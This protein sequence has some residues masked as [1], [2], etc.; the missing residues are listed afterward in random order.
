[1]AAGNNDQALLGPLAA[2]HDSNVV[3]VGASDGSGQ[4][5]SFS[6][7]DA[8]VVDLAAPGVNVLGAQLGGGEAAHSGTSVSTA[9]VAGTAAL[10]WGQ[11]PDQ[12]YEQV[13][14]ALLAGATQE[15]GLASGV[16]GGR[17]LNVQGALEADA[18]LAATPVT[19]PTDVQPAV[20]MA[21]M[22]VGDLQAPRGSSAELTAL[23][24]ILFGQP[25]QPAKD[26]GTT[27]IL[28]STTAMLGVN[29]ICTTTPEVQTVG[30][31]VA[32][33]FAVDMGLPRAT[34]TDDVNAL[35]RTQVVSGSQDA[36]SSSQ[37]WLDEGDVDLATALT[38]R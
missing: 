17:E 10:E 20:N 37:E 6:N 31:S 13:V 2:L 9:F 32:Q 11:R 35:A 18:L 8:S 33:V 4:L 7:A 36:W 24:P 22:T 1:M 26:G 27:S 28:A 14:T 3:V 5:A 25:G 29:L 34:A 23:T 21:G 38:S 30:R 15:P 12:S 16:A 19:Q